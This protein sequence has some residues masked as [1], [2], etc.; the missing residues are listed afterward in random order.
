LHIFVRPTSQYISQSQ[1]SHTHT[2]IYKK[3]CSFFWDL[4]ILIW[5][6]IF[7]NKNRKDNKSSCSFSLLKTGYNVKIE[8][9]KK[10][11]KRSTNISINIYTPVLE[12]VR[13]QYYTSIFLDLSSNLLLLIILA[14]WFNA[15]LLV[16]F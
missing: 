10:N 11:T 7:C 1:H 14:Q 13:F 4:F 2:H 15:P 16:H 8:W 5:H 9:P 3:C 12:Q 6:P